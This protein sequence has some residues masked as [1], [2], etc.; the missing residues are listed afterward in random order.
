MSFD[1]L[2]ATFRHPLVLCCIA[3]GNAL[4]FPMMDKVEEYRLYAGHAL[5]LAETSESPQDKALLLAIAQGWLDLAVAQWLPGA[6]LG[7]ANLSAETPSR[8]RL[9]T[10]GRAEQ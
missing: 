7:D 10:F 4:W 9:G 5:R 6:W 8:A 1:I 3:I 2:A